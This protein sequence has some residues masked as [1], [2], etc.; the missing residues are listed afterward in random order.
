MKNY[1][2]F[3]D[4]YSNHDS[5]KK[6]ISDKNLYKILELDKNC[7]K[8]D[9]KKAYKK[10]ILKYHP[11]KNITDKNSTHKFLKIKNAF[12]I[13]HD[14]EK[15]RTYDNIIFF[16]NTND[17]KENITIDLI[18]I[19]K[20]K[21]LLKNFVNSTEI[22][23]IL[24]IMIKKKI[25]SS[26]NYFNFFYQN[27]ITVENKVNNFIEEIINIDIKINFT[28][29]ELWHGCSKKIIYERVTKEMFEEIIYPFDKIQTYENDGEKI[30][31]NDKIIDGNLNITINI[32]ETK[33][34]NEQY[35]IYMDELYLIIDSKRIVN[36]K[37]TINF[38]DGNNYKFNLNKLEQI[39]KSIGNVYMKKN[40]GLIN[41][42]NIDYFNND[43][44]NNIF[45]SNNH[46]HGNLFFIILL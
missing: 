35:Y 34:N 41:N 20:I 14:D 18:T 33:V 19:Q 46:S 16:D 32:I 36:N 9:I 12:D 13:L 26:I 17:F 29:V 40:F 39:E 4:N 7:T 28:L 3:N 21:I 6:N 37:F 44:F 22:D 2:S 23:K 42:I 25:F 1:E 11:D 15:R 8:N 43:N 38:I 45:F 24:I 5:S 31:F 30:K 27:K 10:L